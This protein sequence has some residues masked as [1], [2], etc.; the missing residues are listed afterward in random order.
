M[1]KLVFKKVDNDYH[2]N[3]ISD[4][5]HNR[6]NVNFVFSEKSE[7]PNFDDG[8]VKLASYIKQDWNNDSNFHLEVSPLDEEQQSDIIF[9]TLYDVFNRFVE[10]YKEQYK[11]IRDQLEKDFSEI[12][13]KHFSE[14]N[15]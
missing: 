7:R 2:V 11:E 13:R 14:F 9:R 10:S 15:D 4:D 1:N 5:K 12:N 8:L 3:L 6:E